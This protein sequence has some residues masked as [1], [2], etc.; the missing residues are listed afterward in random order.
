MIAPAPPQTMAFYLI[1]LHLQHSPASKLLIFNQDSD[2]VF[3]LTAYDALGGTGNIVDPV[4]VNWGG[5]GPL[6]YWDNLTIDTKNGPEP[7]PGPL[8]ILGAAAAFGSVRKLRKFSSLL[9]PNLLA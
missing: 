8:P 6:V 4:S 3:S 5:Q 7:V 9:K 2:V 1:V